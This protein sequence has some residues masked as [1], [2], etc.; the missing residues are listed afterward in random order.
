V[1]RGG[2]DIAL[3]NTAKTYSEGQQH[4]PQEAFPDHRLSQ[5]NLSD[6]DSYRFGALACG[7]NFREVGAC[8]DLI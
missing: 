5:I 6:G 3:D 8:E 1:E 4:F 7:Y 2:F